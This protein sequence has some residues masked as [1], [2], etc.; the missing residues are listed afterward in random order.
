MIDKHFQRIV[1]KIQIAALVSQLSN[2]FGLA[3]ARVFVKGH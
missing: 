1:E 3:V 2:D